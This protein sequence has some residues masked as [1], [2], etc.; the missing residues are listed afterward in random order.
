MSRDNPAHSPC[1]PASR[2]SMDDASQTVALDDDVIERIAV[3]VVE[4][5]RGDVSQPSGSLV[6]A[7]ELARRL[8]VTRD[9]VYAHAS[10]L[11]AVRLGDGPRARLRFDPVEAERA[12]ACVTDRTSRMPET[13]TVERKAARRRKVRS[14]VTA[15]LLPIRGRTAA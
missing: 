11:G 13:G 1:R 4:L 9:Y 2:P 10:T 3:R 8:N 14:G 6:D 15:P 7:A 12:I 5:L